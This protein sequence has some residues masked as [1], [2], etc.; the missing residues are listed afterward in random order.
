MSN[1][2]LERNIQPAA[3]GSNPTPER[4]SPDSGVPT[5]AAAAG[6]PAEP[7]WWAGV[8][9]KCKEHRLDGVSQKLFAGGLLAL[10]VLAVATLL[11]WASVSYGVGQFRWSASVRGVQTGAG[12]L[13]LVLSAAAG[14]F[15]GFTFLKKAPWWVGS[16]YAAGAWG[17]LASL[18]TFWKVIQLGSWAGFG[19]YLA[20]L[21]ALGA[22]VAFGLLALRLAKR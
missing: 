18:F 19:L 2:L 4:A 16:V 13:I 7:A 15:A 9:Q 21:A 1:Q 5:E 17:G 11:S 3:A 22:G 10:A 20:V 8:V 14:V 12:V 6:L